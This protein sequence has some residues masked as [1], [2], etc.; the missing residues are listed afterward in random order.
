MVK[1]S[2]L[3]SHKRSRFVVK[4]TM[5]LNYRVTITAVKF[6]PSSVFT[7]IFYMYVFWYL[8]LSVKI[9]TENIR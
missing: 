7:F 4:L 2:I 8:K 6:I 1:F 5:G 3:D 9:S